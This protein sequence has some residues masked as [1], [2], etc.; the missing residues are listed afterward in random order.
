MLDAT[1]VKVLDA[2]EA[3]VDATSHTVSL[4]EPLISNQAAMVVV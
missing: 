4:L 1:E 2:T 3:K